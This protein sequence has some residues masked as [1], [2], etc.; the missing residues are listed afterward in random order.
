MKQILTIGA[1]LM[2]CLTLQSCF[3]KTSPNMS[4]I[5]K[6]DLSSDTEVAS[7]RVP[8]FLTRTFLKSKIKELD[9][10][11]A[12]AALA[13]RKIKK[14]KVMTISGNKKDNLMTKYHAYLAKNNFEEL[15]SLYSDGSKITINTE[16][17][18]DHVKRVLLG[19]AD[20][21]DYVFVDIKADLDL[22]E[23]SR[24]IEYYENKKEKS[25]I[26]N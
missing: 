19:I 5:S 11:D 24:M 9:E 13:L 14:L 8:M 23:L 4:F 3:V 17:K 22:N 7:V 10:D 15:M 6:R 16:M 2:F 12:V 1:L 18:K 26:I 25:K 21:E 20:E